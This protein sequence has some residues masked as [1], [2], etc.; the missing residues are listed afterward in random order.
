LRASAAGADAVAVARDKLEAARK[1]LQD[2]RDNPRE[3]DVQWIGNKG[4]GTR[5]IESEDFKKRLATLEQNVRRAEEELKVAE[6]R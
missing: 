1:A 5:A 4:G 6:G 2:A 3:G